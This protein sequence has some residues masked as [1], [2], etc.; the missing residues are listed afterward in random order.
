ML[1]G[2]SGPLTRRG[3]FSKRQRYWTNW[4]RRQGY[5]ALLVDSFNPRGVRSVCVKRNRPIRALIHRPHDALAGLAYL[6][7]QKHINPNAIFLLGWSNGGSALLATVGRRKA[8]NTAN[9]AGFRGGDCILSWV[10]KFLNPKRHHWHPKLPTLVL[11]GEKDTWTPPLF[12]KMLHRRVLQ[13][14]D[15]QAAFSIKSFSKGLHGFDSLSPP[16][17]RS[18]PN[19]THSRHLRRVSVG[20]SK[21]GQKWATEQVKAFL[22]EHLP[23]P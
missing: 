6:Q 9:Q 18:V 1:H 5:H 16:R 13:K 17:E 14:M 11:L 19:L 7:A 2:C 23:Q 21:E 20:G 3:Q 8:G 12:C 4:F 15:S 10:Q 22:E